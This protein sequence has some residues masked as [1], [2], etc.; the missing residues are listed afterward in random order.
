MHADVRADQ[1]RS[2]IRNL[3]PAGTLVGL[4]VG[5]EDH[6]LQL[7]MRDAA[8]AC[9]VIGSFVAANRTGRDATDL[10]VLDRMAM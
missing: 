3:A 10:E 9:L 5:F 7:I 4:M 6:G 2:S 1:K 8:V